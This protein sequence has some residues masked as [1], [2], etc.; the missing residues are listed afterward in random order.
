[1]KR[2]T[3]LSLAAI[4][5]TAMLQG[6]IAQSFAQIAETS[7]PLVLENKI[8][9][10]EVKGRID[11]MAFDLARNRLF[12]AELENN[13]VGIVDLNERKVVHVIRGLTEPQGIGHDPSTDTLYVANG[14]DGSVRLFRGADYSET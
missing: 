5:G 3:C 9:L 7:A 1:M 8:V 6:G 11:H 14:G 12:V 2:I 4:A 10:G 13:S